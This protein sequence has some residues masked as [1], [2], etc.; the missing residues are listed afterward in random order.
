MKPGSAPGLQQQIFCKSIIAK[1]GNWPIS[2]Q[3][4]KGWMVFC[5]QTP[6]RKIPMQHALD[7]HSQLNWFLIDTLLACT[8]GM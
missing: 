2:V 5:Q 7:F 4:E 1:G 3:E 6:R 8:P